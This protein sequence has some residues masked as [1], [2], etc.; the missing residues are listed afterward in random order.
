MIESPCFITVIKKALRRIILYFVEHESCV[1]F[2]DSPSG[3][4][5]AVNLSDTFSWHPKQ[6][7]V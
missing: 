5:S 2:K 7:T 1:P 6:L 3:F 4:N